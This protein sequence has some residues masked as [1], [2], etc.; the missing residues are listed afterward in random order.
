[1]FMQDIGSTADTE[2][3]RK[4]LA[5]RRRELRVE[6]LQALSV[7]WKLDVLPRVFAKNG[8]ASQGDTGYGNGYALHQT[9]R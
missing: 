3:S 1:M 4:D 9:Q 8:E 6:I 7:H 2:L 5:L